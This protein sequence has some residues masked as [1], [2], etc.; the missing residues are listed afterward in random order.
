MYETTSIMLQ[1]YRKLFDII[2]TQ[3]ELIGKKG[4]CRY[5]GKDSSQVSFRKK[6]HSF[7]ELIGN[8]YLF[9]HDECNE[10]N[11]YFDKNLENDLANYLG[12][13]R[14]ACGVSGKKNIPKFK[15]NKGERI[16]RIGNNIIVIETNKSTITSEEKS[17]NKAL[18]KVE[19]HPYIPLKV[20]KIFVKMALSMIPIALIGKFQDPINWVR[21]DKKPR[22]YNDSFL[23]MYCSFVTNGNPLPAIRGCLY[24]RKTQSESLPYLFSVV[25][26]GS[27][28][29]QF[30]V[31]F[32]TEDENLNP[33]AVNFLP[34]HPY[35]LLYPNEPPVCDTYEVD[36][37]GTSSVKDID[38]V[39]LIID[40][41]HK[42]QDIFTDIRPE[43]LPDDIKKRI[44]ELGLK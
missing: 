1:E 16:E 43:D 29:F 25:I 38:E 18:I 15:T 39:A 8:K 14:T 35:F 9:S 42:S 24:R 32:S 31:P 13:T 19:K 3:R 5:C 30:I 27:Y 26:F 20:Y 23:K 22:K 17:T 36:L 40:P 11:E 41:K 44:E 12:V 6:A 34:L 37:T 4:C 28:I 33:I 2:L 7:P 21:Y 10:C